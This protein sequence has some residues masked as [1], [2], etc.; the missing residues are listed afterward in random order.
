MN[1]PLA[2]SPGPRALGHGVRADHR[3]RGDPPRQPHPRD[4]NDAVFTQ[5][6]VDRARPLRRHLLPER[7]HTQGPLEDVAH[8]FALGSAATTATGTSS[9]SSIAISAR[10]DRGRGPGAHR[11]SRTGETASSRSRSPSASTCTS[12]CRTPR[13]P[14]PALQPQHPRHAAR[15]SRGCSRSTIGRGRRRRVRSP[16]DRD[17]RV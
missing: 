2:A 9:R 8:D 6:L 4:G 10:L 5:G 3:R 12:R 11:A 14:G 1:R 15:R 16:A 17:G 7:H 13:T